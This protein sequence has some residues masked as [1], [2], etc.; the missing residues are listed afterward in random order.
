MKT[1][2]PNLL[3]VGLWLFLFFLGGCK[4]AEDG[5]HVEPITRY[6]K[7]IGV[8][9]LTGLLQTDELAKATGGTPTS[10][11]L[12]SKFN[13][14]DFKITFK[15]DASNNPTTYEVTGQVPELFSK[16]GF[17]VM[18]AAFNTGK[19]AKILLY[20]DAAKT[21]LSD[22]LEATKLPGSTNELEFRLI[23]SSGDIPFLSYQYS[24]KPVTKP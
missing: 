6:E 17:W 11:S 18:D 8:W 12:Y 3:F 7:I 23:R 22:Q 9:Q 20:E 13:F 21:K 1:R 2:R 14:Q 24:L 10:L 16:K 4:K 15:G 5:A 19:V